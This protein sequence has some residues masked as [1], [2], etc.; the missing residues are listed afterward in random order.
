MYER[1]VVDGKTLLTTYG[2]AHDKFNQA[3]KALEE[4][5]MMVIDAKERVQT[6]DDELKAAI[7]AADDVEDAE[8]LATAREVLKL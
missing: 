1:E 6:A 7:D 4:S 8:A 5:K 2:S 3:S